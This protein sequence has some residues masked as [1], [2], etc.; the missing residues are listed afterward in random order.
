MI[1]GMSGSL[2]SHDAVERLIAS[3]HE[4]ELAPARWL[5]LQRR[6]RA[7]HAELRQLLGPTAGP[8]TVFDLV[9]SPL[10]STLG[11][12]VLPVTAA[13]SAGT[14]TGVAELRCN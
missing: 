8:R 5:P 13:R 11:F 12:A 6:L 4:P 9:A 3:G 7:W 14:E 2:L 1:A 10:V